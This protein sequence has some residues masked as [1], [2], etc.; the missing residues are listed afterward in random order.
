MS[1]RDSQLLTGRRGTS[2]ATMEGVRWMDGW[3]GPE[4][5]M[6]ENAVVQ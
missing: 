6:A 5:G 2:K 3:R 4:Q 1:L